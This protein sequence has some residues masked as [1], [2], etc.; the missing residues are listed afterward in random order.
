MCPAGVLLPSIASHEHEIE[1]RDWRNEENK[2]PLIYHKHYWW[3][4]FY[5]HVLFF[6]LWCFLSIKV[7]FTEF[8]SE[9][10][11]S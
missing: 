5:L 8:C 6:W 10:A 1:V 7:A 11:L 3:D 4:Y 2:E 9:A